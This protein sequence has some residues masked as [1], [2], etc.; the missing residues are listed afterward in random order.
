LKS[1]YFKSEFSIGVVLPWAFRWGIKDLTTFNTNDPKATF[2]D[3][4]LSHR[5]PFGAQEGLFFEHEVKRF[6]SYST[7][8]P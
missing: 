3:P 7:I 5:D 8:A 6:K 4:S 1:A 2:P